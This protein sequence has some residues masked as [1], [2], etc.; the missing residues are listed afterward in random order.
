M[1][2]RLSH[3]YLSQQEL[4]Y[5]IVSKLHSYS[6]NLLTSGKRTPKSQD[7]VYLECIKKDVLFFSGGRKL[8]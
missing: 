5:Q 7:T 6:L 8:L 3:T 1:N 4:S 2:E